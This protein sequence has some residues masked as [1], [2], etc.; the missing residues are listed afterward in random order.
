MEPLAVNVVTAAQ[1]LSVSPR[2]VR[3]LL[4][5]RLRAVRIGRRILVPIDSLRE[6]LLERRDGRN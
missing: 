1:M 6:L 3:R 4:G 2:T 5:T